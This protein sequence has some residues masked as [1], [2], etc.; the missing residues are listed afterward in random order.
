MS[1]EFCP[2][3]FEIK[4]IA[5]ELSN[6]K[7]V[8]IEKDDHLSFGIYFTDSVYRPVVSF[9]YDSKMY[10]VTG[11]CDDG[12]SCLYL[13][14]SD[15][16]VTK[17]YVTSL[18]RSLVVYK[19]FTGRLKQTINSQN[20]TVEYA[21]NS[22]NPDYTFQSGSGFAWPIRGVGASNNGRWLAV[23]FRDRGIGLLDIDSLQMKRIS[24]MALGY[25][26]GYIVGSQFSVSNDGQHV[27]IMGT[28]AGLM[29]FDVNSG[30]GDEATDDRMISVIPITKPCKYTG[31]DT[32]EFIDNF[33]QALHPNFSDDGGELDFYAISSLSDV[34]EVALRAAGYG[35]QR[36]DYL[37]LGDSFSSG[38]GETSDSEYLPGTNE[39]FEK[40]HVSARSYPFL[41]AQMSGI[42]PL[43]MRSVACSGAVTKDII[44]NDAI[45]KGQGD[46]LGDRGMMFNDADATLAK[47]EAKQQITPGRV[48]QESLVKIYRPNIITIGIGGNDAGF[49]QKLV[50]CLGPDTC[51]WASDPQKKEQTAIE[52]KN[53]F[54]DLVN[55]YQELHDKSPNSKIYAIGYPKIINP[56]GE[57]GPLIGYLLNATER[58]FMSEG[59]TY[60]DQIIEAAANKVGIKYLDIADSFSGHAICDGT[61]STAMN[62]IRTGDDSSVINQLD[63]FKFIGQESFHPTP[64]GHN[65]IAQTINSAVDGNILYYNYCNNGNSVC[66]QDIAP[67]EPSNYWIPTDNNDSLATQKAVDFLIDDNDPE[68]VD[69]KISLPKFSMTPDSEATIEINSTPQSLGQFQIDDSGGLETTIGL[70]DSLE[71]GYHTI[72]IYGTSF[73]GEPVDFYQSTQVYH[74]EII[75]NDQLQPPAITPNSP[76]DM[77]ITTDPTTGATV[78]NEVQVE[79]KTAAPQ[80]PVLSINNP[81]LIEATE[82]TP[83]VLGSSTKNSLTEK[84][85]KQK[86]A[87]FDNIQPLIAGFVILTAICLGLFY[88][89]RRK[90]H[91]NQ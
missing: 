6:P 18:M 37:A 21:F 25:G 23:D 28:N 5:G 1:P 46:R 54:E 7:K 72:H 9:G 34:R 65:L 84:H 19:N 17:Q 88:V 15:T 59:I 80:E 63:W 50:T 29:V 35:G 32:S 91:A 79:S 41:V 44:G 55:T 22:T 58:Q 70:P 24:T 11:I 76:V 3:S 13:P 31:V 45:Y 14:G 61:D 86:T 57:C 40:C 47:T 75:L 71:N 51:T 2:K 30:C 33:S 85:R 60:L 90:K 52:I 38:E 74:P 4:D 36:L 62:T 68:S 56:T 53:L 8:C 12:D 10:H 69:R 77:S 89:G 42:D 81:G 83:S 67:P 26:I 78:S 66:P 48:H 73:S 43:Y 20:L 39:E 64:F 27:A 87:E 16:L 82:S 49:M